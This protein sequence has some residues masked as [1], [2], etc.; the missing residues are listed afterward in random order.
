[1][2]R[3]AILILAAVIALPA[4]ANC[5]DSEGISTPFH[6]GAGARALALGGSDVVDPDPST[7]AYWNPS[8]LAR[9]QRLTI[10]AFHT[11]LFEPGVDYQHFGLCIPTLDFGGFGLG[12]FR[13]GVGDID[14]RDKDN[15]HTGT[16]DE[17]RMNVYL[18][19]G[20]KVRSFDLGVSL[21]IEH[22]S[23]ADYSATSSPGL[24]L[25]ASRS[26]SI[27]KKNLPEIKLGVN[28][29][30]LLRPSTKLD[31]YSYDM[32]Y[33]ADAGIGITLIPSVAWN[34]AANLYASLQKVDQVDPV[35][36][37]G[38]EY[39]ISELLHLRGG[40]SGDK[41]SAGVG[42]K[43]QM[44]AFDYAYVDRDLDA[45]H[46]FSLGLR[47]GKT[48][49]Q[50]RAD[51]EARIESE[52]NN[53]L[54]SQLS[55]RNRDMIASLI[56]DGSTLLADEKLDEAYAKFD[57]ARF[58]ATASDED[59]LEITQLVD[60]TLAMIEARE[61]EASLVAFQDSAQSK[62]EA[63]DHLGAK[64]F[65][66]RALEIDP[67]CEVSRN[68]ISVVD[69]RLNQMSSTISLIEERLLVVD[70]L[71]DYGK[72]SDALAALQAIE[73]HADSMPRVSNA[74]KR[75]TFEVMREKTAVAFGSSRFEQARSLVD[76]ASAIFADHPW[77]AEMR[78]R[79]SGELR[80]REETRLV[81]APR[82]TI[83]PTAGMRYTADAA[84]AE[85]RELFE[86]GNLMGAI[87]KW[88]SVIQLVPDHK[89]VRKHLIEAYKYFGVELYGLGKLDEA[90]GL[91]R[92]AALLDP[93][94]EEIAEYIK[95]TEIEITKLK[96]LT[97]E[98]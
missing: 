39:S 97:Y 73:S 85:G 24:H 33:T 69:A 45:L 1:M 11:R 58:L 80:R 15:L 41:L 61:R 23:I 62:L 10:G 57:R 98:Y 34:H 16:T 54:S 46:T 95:R 59:S 53:Y 12:V 18:G 88:E 26:I 70:S 7:A 55:Q 32:P 63:G 81:E 76:S 64:Y 60:S 5:G 8:A 43:Y 30:N 42:V 91:W 49:D 77:C 29:R 28:G 2:S 22:Q 65:A 67:E 68:V 66:E 35:G 51:R 50:K 89:S 3:I 82:S 13:L 20:R 78:K 27:G 40:L 21:N 37:A 84:Y 47:F 6:M 79:I 71:L 48:V 17:S 36:S 72:S 87:E 93:E 44:V 25:S 52:F 38:L 75:A 31:E 86:V 74:L 83:E 56:A 94:N 19:Y 90:I 4:I 96:E 9:A 92:K 14:M